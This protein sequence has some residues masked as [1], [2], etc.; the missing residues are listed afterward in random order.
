MET[1]KEMIRRAR[2]LETLRN[3]A[4]IR[5]RRVWSQIFASTGSIESANA[6]GREEW[7]ET[8]RAVREISAAYV[9]RV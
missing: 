7:S 6:A 2:A 8:M 4:E 9:V 5:S 1:K 3:L